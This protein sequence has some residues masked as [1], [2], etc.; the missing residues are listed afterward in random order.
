MDQVATTNRFEILESTD[1]AA[2][3]TKH[4]DTDTSDPWKDTFTPPIVSVDRIH[5]P[6]NIADFVTVSCCTPKAQK[7]RVI[8]TRRLVSLL[9]P[10]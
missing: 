8:S 3:D 9:E 5:V 4:Q 1:T 2:L 10:C 6:S 7:I